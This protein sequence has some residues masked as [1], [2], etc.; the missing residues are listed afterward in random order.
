MK[1]EYVHNLKM[2][3]LDEPCKGESEERERKR[4]PQTMSG[5]GSKER[6]GNWFSDLS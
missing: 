6:G 2:F 3:R 4:M 1:F 5:E